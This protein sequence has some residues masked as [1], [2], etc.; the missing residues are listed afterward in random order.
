MFHFTDKEIEA[1]CRMGA[2]QLREAKLPG[3]RMLSCFSHVQLCDPMDCN[4]Q[5]SSVRGVLQARTMEWVAI[6][7]SR[8]SSLPRDPT[9]VSCTAGGFFTIWATR[10]LMSFDLTGLSCSPSFA[11]SFKKCSIH[12]DWQ[13]RKEFL[14]LRKKNKIKMCLRQSHYRH[15]NRC[16]GPTD[17][18]KRPN[19]VY[20]IHKAHSKRF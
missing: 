13:D 4:P 8:G 7:I 18:C 9:Q 5:G 2:T 12:P 15:R 20:K 17:S 3:A 6:P 14:S 11:Y 19:T 1:T 16:P 10:E